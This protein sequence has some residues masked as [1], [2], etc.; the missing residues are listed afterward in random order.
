MTGVAHRR[1]SQPEWVWNLVLG[2]GILLFVVAMSIT[3]IVTAGDWDFWTDWKDAVF[4]PLAMPITLILVLSIFQYTLWRLVRIPGATILALS[5]TVLYHWPR[6]FLNFHLFTDYPMNFV[7]PSVIIP[8]A[9]LLDVS[10]VLT[11]KWFYTAFLGG[12]AFGALFFAQNFPAVAPFRQPLVTH[13][14][15]MTVADLQGAEYIRSAT[16]EYK[17]IVETGGLRTFSGQTMV[18][19]A[20]LAGVLC[21]ISYGLGQLFARRVV[22]WP[23]GRYLKRVP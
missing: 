2:A 8:G 6:S 9:I 14:A 11:R 4:F 3:V 13:H 12:F 16:P 21:T 17:R 7:W 20:G 15:V 22:F 18:T 19:T 5:Y 1:A 10:F 23:V